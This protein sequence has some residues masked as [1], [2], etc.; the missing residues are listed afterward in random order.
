[1]KDKTDREII[2]EIIYSKLRVKKMCDE[3][4]KALK[5]LNNKYTY[6]NRPS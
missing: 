4:L 1:M 6:E 3:I 2:L 5:A